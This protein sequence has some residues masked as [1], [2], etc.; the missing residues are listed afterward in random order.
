MTVYVNIKHSSNRYK[1]SIPIRSYFFK[2]VIWSPFYLCFLRY[3]NLY[4]ICDIL[5]L[6]NLDSIRVCY[7]YMFTTIIGYITKLYSLLM[8]VI[9]ESGSRERE[10]NVVCACTLSTFCSNRWNELISYMSYIVITKEILI[11]LL[12]V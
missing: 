2:I 12:K 10:C 3:T 4:L 5:P 1:Y 9:Y 7:E 6:E 8:S 11:F